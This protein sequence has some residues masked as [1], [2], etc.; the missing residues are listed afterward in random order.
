MITAWNAPEYGW[1]YMD[2]FILTG[3]NSKNTDVGALEIYRHHAFRNCI[4]HSNCTERTQ[5][6]T[7]RILDW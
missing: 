3:V 4:I 7:L 1:Y 5:E 2:G 6:D